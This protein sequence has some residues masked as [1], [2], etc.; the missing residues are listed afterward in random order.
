MNG[1]HKNENKRKSVRVPVNFETQVAHQ[2]KKHKAGALNLSVDG[3]C[4]YSAKTFADNDRIL[5]LF[6]LPTMQEPMRLWAR[7]VWGR[8]IESPSTTTFGMGIQF[9]HPQPSQKK[10]LV[11]FIQSL[12]KS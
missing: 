10:E 1:A 2:A 9:E 3:M 8:T 4:L 12:L 11:K 7:V 6:K 5:V